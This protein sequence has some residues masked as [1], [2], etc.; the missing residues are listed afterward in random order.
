MIAEGIVL[1]LSIV[2]HVH[3]SYMPPSEDVQHHVSADSIIDLLGLFFHGDIGENHLEEY[4]HQVSNI[5]IDD[6]S[7][8]LVEIA[9][10]NHLVD[11]LFHQPQA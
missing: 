8:V 5:E 6:H 11:E 9:I 4:T 3:H 2:P 10:D 7:F 1:L